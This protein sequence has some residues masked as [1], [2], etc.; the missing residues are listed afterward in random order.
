MENNGNTFNSY[1]KYY[2][3]AQKL[4]FQF[5]LSTLSF[6]MWFS[7]S[8]FKKK[9]WFASD[10][11]CNIIHELCWTTGSYMCWKLYSTRSLS[12]LFAHS[13]YFKF[14]GKCLTLPESTQLSSTT[15]KKEKSFSFYPQ[16]IN[17]EQIF[18]NMALCSK[19][20]LRWITRALGW[21]TPGSDRCPEA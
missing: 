13:G 9:W 2:S 16:A 12:F 10:S 7:W 14:N 15:N 19:E 6:Y 17:L 4:C 21:S 11:K 20:Q 1:T 8:R 3:I 18:K 5:T